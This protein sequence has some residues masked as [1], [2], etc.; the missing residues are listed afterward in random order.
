MERIGSLNNNTD[1]R[2]DDYVERPTAR[3]DKEQKNYYRLY[4]RLILAL[5]RGALAVFEDS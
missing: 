4:C 1:T 2:S 5:L 3:T